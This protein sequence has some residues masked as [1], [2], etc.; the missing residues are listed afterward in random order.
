M[1]EL[2]TPV[3]VPAVRP[4]AKRWA[5]TLCADPGRLGSRLKSQSVPNLD[6]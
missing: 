3:P 2:A 6:K 5:Q 1:R 4:G